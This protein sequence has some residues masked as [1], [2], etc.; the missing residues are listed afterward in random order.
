MN[1][2]DSISY[3]VLPSFAQGSN[4][5]KLHIGILR[6]PFFDVTFPSA[7]NF[8]SIGAVIGHEMVHGFD[9][10]GRKH[11]SNGILRQWW[12]RA[13]I[14]RFEKRA[15]C[16]KL[17]YSNFTVKGH[18]IDGEQTLGMPFKPCSMV[19]NINTLFFH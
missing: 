3:S 4:V 1:R 18:P 19:A 14:E 8:G 16:F 6:K 9:N 11:D 10:E 12:N 5:I 17:Q 15:E 2:W 13:A 7:Y